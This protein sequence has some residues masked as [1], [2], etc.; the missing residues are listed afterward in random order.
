M[1]MNVLRTL[2][3][4]ILSSTLF[5]CATVSEIKRE[6]K[7][8]HDIANTD[9]R[10]GLGYLQQGRVDAALVK[11]KKA[12]AVLPDYPEAHSVIALVYDQL[13]EKDKAETHYQ[14]ALELM[15]KDGAAH[16]NYAV[17]LC[18][19]GRPAEAEPY[20]LKA[21][22]SRNYRTPAQAWENLGLCSL[23]IPDQKKAERYL[24]KALQLDPRLPKALLKMAQISLDKDNAMSGR[25]YLS[26]Y[27]EVTALNAEGLWLG[28][29]I[30]KK[31]GGQVR[32]R[33][34]KNRLY[35]HFPDSQELQL[36]IESE[37][38]TQV[39]PEVKAAGK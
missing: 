1:E 11:L 24:R 9:V 10:L 32:V 7:K 22:Q 28:I 38:E 33:D 39:K 2:L 36:L 35:R 16:N 13:G 19:T 4:V 3:I 23:K 15:P 8:N 14:R 26:R 29:Q 37:K 5:A 25:A 34:Y 6:E 17:F 12:L 20:F 18:H 27:Q 21:I 30:E 31:L